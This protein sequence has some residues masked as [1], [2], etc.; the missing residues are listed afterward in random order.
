MMSSGLRIYEKPRDKQW[1]NVGF[2]T[3][4][5]DGCHKAYG[6]CELMFHARF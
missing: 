3:W 4:D 1:E 2:L 5:R 6:P